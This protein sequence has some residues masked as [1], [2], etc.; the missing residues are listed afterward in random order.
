MKKIT[1]TLTFAVVLFNI[2]FAQNIEISDMPQTVNQFIE[3]RN[4]TAITPQ[5]G[6]AM[7]IIALKMYK[8]NPEIGKQCLVIAADRSR[9]QKGDVYK[10][11]QIFSTDMNRI[12]RQTESYPYVVD[13][14]FKGAN[15]SN[16]YKTK[17]PYKLKFSSN[18]YSGN[19]KDGNFK[20]FV[21]SYGASSP[22]PIRM[23]KNNKGYWKAKEWSS[24][25]MGIQKPKVTVNDDL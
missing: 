14:Y 16:A 23:I 15:P 18:A 1:L 8:E 5:G 21:K 9:L 22:R 13:S 10:N 17:L 6:A 4:K 7:F 3:L 25:I 12:K 24:I 20:I 2:I 19:I 11:F